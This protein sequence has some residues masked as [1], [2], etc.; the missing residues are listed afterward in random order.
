MD[1]TVAGRFINK[2]VIGVAAAILIG[3]VLTNYLMILPVAAVVVVFIGT[4]LAFTVFVRRIDYMV[5]LWFAMSWLMYPIASQFPAAYQSLVIRSIF[6]GLIFCMTVSWFIDT[7]LN[8][9]K[10]T[11][12]DDTLIKY[13]V[14]IFLLWST[15]PIFITPSI[16]R[17]MVTISRIL[18]ALIT[19]YILYDFLSWSENNIKRL[20]TLLSVLVVFISFGTLIDAGYKSISGIYIWKNIYAVIGQNPLGYFLFISCPIMI[21][22]GFNFKDNKGLKVFFIVILLLALFFS[23]S[24]TCWFTALI[25]ISFL[26]W[27]T[28]RKVLLVISIILILL[29]GMGLFAGVGEDFYRPYI[30]E[31]GYGLTGTATLTTR[32]QKW[33]EAWDIIRNYPMFGSGGRVAVPYLHGVHLNMALNNGIPSLT[34]ILAFYA[35]FFYSSVRI[36]KTLKSRYLKLIVTGSMATLLGL[37]VYGIFENV[38]ILTDYGAVGWNPLYPYVIAVLPFAAKKIEERQEAAARKQRSAVS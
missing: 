17:S 12:F 9:R 10:P 26:L 36:E 23:F 6:W 37:I 22:S 28:G 4:V 35:A 16:F 32:Y 5:F 27:K 31:D 18:I 29:V 21:T 13:I 11:P 7:V 15:I 3:L 38:G 1:T 20:L 8:R 34:F 24:R 2:Y 33:Q 19:S 25:S 30:Q 14:F